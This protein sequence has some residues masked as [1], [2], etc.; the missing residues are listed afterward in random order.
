[1]NSS[2]FVKFVKNPPNAHRTSNLPT[3]TILAELAAAAPALVLFLVLF[4]VINPAL[5]VE[6]AVVGPANPNEP[7]ETLHDHFAFVPILLY[8]LL[9]LFIYDSFLV[10]LSVLLSVYTY[11]SAVK[12]NLI[13]FFMVW[14][15]FFIV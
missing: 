9:V 15:L 5:T 13:V 8:P 1:M 12:I 11:Q 10:L 4:C 3:V 2:M 6:L 14:I 7:V